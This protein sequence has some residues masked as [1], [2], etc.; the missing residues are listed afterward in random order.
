MDIPMKAILKDNNDTSAR[1]TMSINIWTGE[2]DKA[3]G[4]TFSVDFGSLLADG[5]ERPDDWAR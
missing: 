3:Q 4:W 2:Q 5:W 1:W